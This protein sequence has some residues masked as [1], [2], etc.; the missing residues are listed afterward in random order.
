MEQLFP[1]AVVQRSW[2]TQWRTN[3]LTLHS[4]RIRLC[5]HLI[6]YIYIYSYMVHVWIYVGRHVNMCIWQCVELTRAD[7]IHQIVVSGDDN[8]LVRVHFIM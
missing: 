5:V 8:S 1:V 6:T 7:N 3:A 2:C 4:H